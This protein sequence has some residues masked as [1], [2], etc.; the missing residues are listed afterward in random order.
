M[1]YS[2]YTPRQCQAV[3]DKLIAARSAGGGTGQVSV[4]GVS[5]QWQGGMELTTEIKFWQAELAKANGVA[6]FAT[7]AR[8]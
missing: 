4:E 5:V 6:P 3:L 7:F 1:R 8:Y 2:T